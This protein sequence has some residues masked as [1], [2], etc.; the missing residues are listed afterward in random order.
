MKLSAGGFNHVEA[1]VK[2]KTE[3]LDLDTGD[4]ADLHCERAEGSSD[5]LGAFVYLKGCSIALLGSR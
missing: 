4:R 2:D 1:R 5:S 3:L